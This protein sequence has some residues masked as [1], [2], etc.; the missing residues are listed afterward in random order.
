[1][2]KVVG[3][4]PISRFPLQS[5]IWPRLD[6]RCGPIVA[7]NAPVVLPEPLRTPPLG[8][9][10]DGPHVPLRAGLK[11][12]STFINQ[13]TIA[14][15]EEG[16]AWRRKPEEV[17][18]AYASELDMD[19]RLLASRLRSVARTRAGPGR[20]QSG[21]D[22]GGAQAAPDLGRRAALARRVSQRETSRR[23]ASGGSSRA[24]ATPW[25]GLMDDPL[26]GRQRSRHRSTSSA[27]TADGPSVDL[28]GLSGRA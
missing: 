25:W 7:Q 23:S 10:G 14:R 6:F 27:A 12:N 15:F 19:V 5:Q 18:M 3:S 24:A 11:P 28:A 20:G 1:M 26:V 8:L 2:Q 22:S 4:N 21:A 13:A 16:I 9:L 17:L